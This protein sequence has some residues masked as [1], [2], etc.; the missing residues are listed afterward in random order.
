MQ[1]PSLGSEITLPYPIFNFFNI[2][3]ITL[4]QNLEVYQ[5]QIYL[6]STFVQHT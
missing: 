1:T 2:R 4:A 6:L 5:R 3:Q